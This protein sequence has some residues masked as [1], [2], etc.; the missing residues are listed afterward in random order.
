MEHGGRH[1]LLSPAFNA[2]HVRKATR[3][4]QVRGSRAGANTAA[5]RSLAM[6]I[7]QSRTGRSRTCVGCCGPTLLHSAQRACAQAPRQYSTASSQRFLLQNQITFSE[8]NKLLLEGAALVK[9][10]HICYPPLFPRCLQ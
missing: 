3:R 5:F 6:A 9:T 7:V 8:K 1:V 10:Q 4:T 2:L